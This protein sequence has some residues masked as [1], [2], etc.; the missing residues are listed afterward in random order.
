MSHHEKTPDFY[1]QP[2]T[3]PEHNPPTHIYIPVGQAYIHECPLCGQATKLTSPT[4]TL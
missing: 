2:C 3:S 4:I 1:K